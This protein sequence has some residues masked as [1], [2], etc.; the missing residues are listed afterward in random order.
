M[1]KRLD[2]DGFAFLGEHTFWKTSGVCADGFERC[3]TVAVAE[4]CARLVE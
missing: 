1:R 2:G 3:R 4:R